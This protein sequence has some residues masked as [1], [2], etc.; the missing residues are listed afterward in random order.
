MK[1][2]TKPKELPRMADFAIH[3][4]I[5]ARCIGYDKGVFLKAFNE[6]TKLQSAADRIRIHSR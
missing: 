1:G 2:I 3:G 4:E 5:V 6:N